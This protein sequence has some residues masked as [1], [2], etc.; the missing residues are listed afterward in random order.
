MSFTEAEK[1][2][3][4]RLCGFPP[5]G[6]LVLSGAPI[7]VN[8]LNYRFQVNDFENRLRGLTVTE[9]ASARATLVETLAIEASMFTMNS[10]LDI[11]H[12]AVYK[13]NPLEMQ[14]RLQLLGWYRQK[15]LTV[16]GAVAGPGM[17]ATSSLFGV[18]VRG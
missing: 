8:P 2:D 4:R 17:A 13:R 1:T 7:G 11:D 3:I 16:L 9:E 15:L 5:I 18:A 6:T 14:E 10:G 12:A